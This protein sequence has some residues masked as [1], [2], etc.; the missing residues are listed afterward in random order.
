MLV[1]KAPYENKPHLFAAPAAVCALW[2]ITNIWPATVIAA[3]LGLPER[4]GLTEKA[5]RP[6]PLPLEP[7]LM[8]TQDIPS[9]TCQRQPASVVTCIF[10]EP[11]EAANRLDLGDK[12]KVQAEH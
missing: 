7:P 12:E 4:L 1:D 6:A 10:D 2:V 5:T 8:V 3:V 9:T 11:P